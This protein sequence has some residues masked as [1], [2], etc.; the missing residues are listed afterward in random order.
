[1]LFAA[2]RIGC[3]NVVGCV[4]VD[5][6]SSYT[7]GPIQALPGITKLSITP[8][9]SVETLFY[10]DGPGDTATTLGK[11][12]VELDKS[13]LS[14]GEKAF[15]LGHQI[16]SK[17]AL[18]YGSAD[19][20]PW[21]AIG[22]RTLK[23]NGAYRYVWMLKGKFMENDDK[24]ETK[25]DKINFQQET[26]KGNF[27]RLNTPFVVNGKTI[28]PWRTDIDGEDAGANA[29]AI[30]G[31]FNAVY[32]P[33]VSAT[34]AVAAAVS[35][36]MAASVATTGATKATITGAASSYY[37]ASVTNTSVGTVY[38]G[39]QLP[40][41]GNTIN[42]YVSA[43]DIINNVAVGKFVQIYNMSAA[44]VVVGFYEHQLIA[45]DIK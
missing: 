28:K 41:N 3:D 39:D 26:L 22:F 31:W 33:T 2:T 8:N 16:D 32:L 36:V 20:P 43:Q 35:V 38:A 10:D 12:A 27:T 45:G 40:V 25:G 7:T 23:S 30:A 19:V 18:V 21:V 4:I 14:T 37:L 24:S 17:G 15:L 1:M 9:A 34:P 5:N 42:P 44:N 13:S 6:G 29:A 11:I